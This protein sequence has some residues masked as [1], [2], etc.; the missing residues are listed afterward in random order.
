MLTM[1]ETPSLERRKVLKAFGAHSV[2][3]AGAK[4]IPSGIAKAGEIAAD[5]PDRL[6]VPQR[7]RNPA[8]REKT[9]SPKIREAT[10][11]GKDLLMSGVGAGGTLPHIALYE[12]T[13]A[14]RRFPRWRCVWAVAGFCRQDV[15]RDAAR[16]RRAISVEHFARGHRLIRS[17]LQL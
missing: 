16:F 2:L 11:G 13:P 5:D 12:S 4:G 10:D 1:P 6:F 15:C 3:T 9:T 8:I 7:L 17:P 14:A